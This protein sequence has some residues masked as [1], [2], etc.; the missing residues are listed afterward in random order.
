MSNTHPFV[1]SP[2]SIGSSKDTKKE[3]KKKDGEKSK[4]SLK[5]GSVVVG[6]GS[7]SKKSKAAAAAAAAASAAADVSVAVPTGGGGDGGDNEATRV[8]GVPLDVAVARSKC[9]DGLRLPLAVRMCIDHIEEHGLMIE[10]VYRYFV[11]LCMF[12]CDV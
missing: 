7:S 5:L 6:G 4:K 8:F 3:S 12:V 2:S 11:A 10:G 1:C 9:H